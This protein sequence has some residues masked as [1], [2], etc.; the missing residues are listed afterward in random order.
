MRSE[1]TKTPVSRCD[2]ARQ[3]RVVIERYK[4]REEKDADAPDLRHLPLLATGTAGCVVVSYLV[5][6]TDALIALIEAGDMD[7]GPFTLIPVGSANAL[8][9]DRDV[10]KY[11]T[12]PHT[13]PSEHIVKARCSAAPR[14]MRCATSAAKYATTPR[15]KTRS[16]CIPDDMRN[17]KLENLKAVSRRPNLATLSRSE[18]LRVGGE[19]TWQARYDAHGQ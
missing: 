16:P 18:W 12:V 2:A 1:R 9:H 4:W 19:D 7:R 10:C 3:L 15:G 6:H 8:V 11:E 13:A 14:S 5:E 17:T